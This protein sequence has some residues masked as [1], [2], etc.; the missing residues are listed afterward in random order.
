MVCKVKGI[1]IKTKSIPVIEGIDRK[2]IGGKGKQ[3]DRHAERHKKMALNLDSGLC[4]YTEQ[5]KARMM[6]I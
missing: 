6:H 5:K 4:K 1:T 3:S 2:S